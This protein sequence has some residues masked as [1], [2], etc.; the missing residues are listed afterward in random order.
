MELQAI[1]MRLL[2]AFVIAGIDRGG[3][4]LLVGGRVVLVRCRG[5]CSL[6]LNCRIAA[7]TASLHSVLHAWGPSLD[8]IHQRRHEVRCLEQPAS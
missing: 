7:N 6:K 3:I 1:E 8:D 5:L 4:L 2:E